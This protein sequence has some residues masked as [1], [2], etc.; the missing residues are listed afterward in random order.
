MTRRHH[1]AYPFSVTLI[2]LA[3]IAFACWQLLRG[4]GPDPAEMERATRMP[5]PGHS[6]VDRLPRWDDDEVVVIQERGWPDVRVRWGDVRE[7]VEA[8][9]IPRTQDAGAGR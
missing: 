1:D 7:E 2:G 6:R 4:C 8:R 5:V 9:M 3:V